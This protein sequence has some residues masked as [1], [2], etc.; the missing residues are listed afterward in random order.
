VGATESDMG[1]DVDDTVVTA[2]VGLKVPAVGFELGIF[3]ATGPSVGSDVTLV[4]GDKVSAT[5]LPVPAMG[6]ADV[7][8]RVCATGLVVP[9]AGLVVGKDSSVMGFAVGK[10]VIGAG[11]VG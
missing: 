10:L 1:L 9:S 11:V 2:G 6:L 8:G 4:V 3:P 5:G 7:G